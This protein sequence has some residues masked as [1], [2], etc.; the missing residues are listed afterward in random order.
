MGGSYHTWSSTY[1]D[2]QGLLIN[3]CNLKLDKETTTDGH[4]RIH[5]NG[6]YYHKYVCANAV[7]YMYGDRTCAQ[8]L[9][10]YIYHTEGY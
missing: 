2:C 9:H 1:P 3:T 10:M 8:E 5:L 6:M 4:R 7:K